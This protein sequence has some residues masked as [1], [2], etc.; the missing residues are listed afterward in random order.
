MSFA[1]LSGLSPHTPTVASFIET[2]FVFGFN[3]NDHGPTTHPLT[4]HDAYKTISTITF[5]DSNP[6]V[7]DSVPIRLFAY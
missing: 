2:P 7:D 5:D 3:S 1:D 4:S 6:N